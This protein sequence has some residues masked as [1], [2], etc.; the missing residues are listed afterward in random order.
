M[1]RY[2]VETVDKV[3]FCLTVQQVISIVDILEANDK[4]YFCRIID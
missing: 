2:V 4:E 3:Y 1:K